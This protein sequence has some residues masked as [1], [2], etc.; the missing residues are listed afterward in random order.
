MKRLVAAALEVARSEIGT[1]E[2][3]VNDGPKVRGFLR[4]AGIGVPAPWCCAFVYYCIKQA[5]EVLDVPNP[6]VKTAYCPS[7]ANWAKSEGVLM[8]KPAAG[9]IFLSY[10]R[11]GG[12]YRAF[13]TG[14]VSGVEGAR[15]A[16]TEGNT[17][18]GGSRE[19]VGVFARTR[20]VSG[21]YKFV[22]WGALVDEP[23]SEPLIY[24]LV[25]ASGGPLAKMPV[26][27]GRAYVSVRLLGEHIGSIVTWSNEEQSVRFDGKEIPV[28]IV[29]EDGKAMAAIRDLATAVGLQLA[30]DAKL[31]T[32]RL[33]RPGV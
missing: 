23:D 2:R 21:A 29:L 32:V 27:N 9:D 13:H 26:R 30:V 8:T 15:F 1:R 28:E 31:R 14:F 10:G 3:G 11:T 12:V 19:G 7:L 33:V 25:A 16:T 6:L 5:A 17:N 4:A 18:I 22:R 24:T 20:P